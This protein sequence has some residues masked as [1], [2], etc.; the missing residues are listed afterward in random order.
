LSMEKGLLRLIAILIVSSSSI[1][2]AVL[3]VGIS[4]SERQ[5]IIQFVRNKFTN[6]I[7]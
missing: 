1:G 5:M 4:Q 6:K 2:L 3:I 7:K